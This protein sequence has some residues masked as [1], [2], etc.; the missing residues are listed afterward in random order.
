MSTVKIGNFVHTTG[1]RLKSERKRLCL[2]QLQLADLCGVALRSQQNYEKDERQPD[3]GYLSAVA[4]AGVDVLYVIT[5]VR[6]E[7]TASTPM[8]LAYLRNCRALPSM[9][10]RKRGLDMLCYL[11]EAY[12]VKLYEHGAAE[13]G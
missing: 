11:R 9:D 6:G 10:A 4:T 3:A 7:N 8:E 12:G 13:E 5:G 2:S 1:S